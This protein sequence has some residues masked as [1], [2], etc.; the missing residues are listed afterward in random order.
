MD[1]KDFQCYVGHMLLSSMASSAAPSTTPSWVAVLGTVSGIVTAIGVLVAGAFA[2]FKFVKGRTLRPRCSID[3][4]PRLIR[5]GGNR[6]LQVSIA[7]KNEGQVALLFP[8]D[9]PQRLLIGQADRYLW[10]QA[11]E[12]GQPVRWE[13]S[14]FPEV[15][16]SLA[17]PEGAVLDPVE[18]V[19]PPRLRWVRRSWLLEL[20]D[21]DKLEPGE[22]WMRSILVPVAADSV[23]YLLRVWVRACRHV[24]IRHTTSHRLHCCKG[25]TSPLSWWREVYVLP[26]E[27]NS[28]DNGRKAATGTIRKARQGTS[29]P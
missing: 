25:K 1:N 17:V 10:K 15:R 18:V 2:Y 19:D 9:V 26:E 3:I 13:D 16:W 24:A 6:A 12:T 5:I 11:Y 28:D 29:L 4:S 8:S 14:K 7:V 23:A 21:G 27:G 22:Q 20:L